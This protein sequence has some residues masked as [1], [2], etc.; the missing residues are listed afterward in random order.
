MVA[1][2]RLWQRHTALGPLGGATAVIAQL[3]SEFGEC[4]F[5][6]LH[7]PCRVGVVD[8]SGHYR[9]A[10]DSFQA[11][12]E[13]GA[14]NYVGVLVGLF[15]DTGGSFVNLKESQILAASDGD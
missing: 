14:D 4:A 8:P 10:D 15:A 7:L 3:A 6:R 11:F 12:I 2:R 13:G 5:C 9:D 1:A